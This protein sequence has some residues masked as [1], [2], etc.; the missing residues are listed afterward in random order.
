MKK[1]LFIAISALSLLAIASCEKEPKIDWDDVT[2]NGFYVSG[3]ATGIDGVSSDCVMAAGLNEVDKTKRAGMYE[4][5]IVLEAGKEFYLLYNDGK[6]KSRYS[7]TLE[8]FTTP[9]EEAYSDNPAQVL[10]GSLVIGNDAPAMKVSKT[11]LYHIVLDI[12]KAN[13]LGEKYKDGVIVLL[14]ASDFG[15]RGGMNSWGFTSSDP[16]PEFKNEGITF[17]FK[18][19]ELAKNGE[20]KFSTGNYWKVTLDDAGKVKA[21][22]SLGETG[23]GLGLA[24]NNNI[25]VEKGGT[26]DITLTFKLA[27]GEFNKSFTYTAECTKESTAPETMYMI[28]NAFGNWDWASDGIVELSGIPSAPGLF[29]CTRYFTAADEFKFCA[30]KAWNGDFGDN[31]NNCKV[32]SDGFYTVFVDGNN[33]KAEIM[34]AEVYGIGDAWGADA[35]DFNAPDA[36]K[37]VAEGQVLKATVKNNSTAVR[38][39]SKVTPSAPIEGVTTGNGWIDWWKTEFVY[40]DGKI[41]YRGAGNDQ[42]RVA[43]EAG[44]VITIDFNAGTVTVTDGVVQKPTVKDFAQGFVKILDVW[45]TTTG[46]GIMYEGVDPVKNAHLIPLDTKLTIAGKEYTTADLWET[47]IRSY[48]LIRGYNGLDTENY[49]A[50]KIGPLSAGAQAMSDLDIPE[51]HQYAWGAGPCNETSGNGGHLVRVV[52]GKDVHCQVQVDILDNFAMRALNF[53][54]GKTISNM[55]T[56]PRDPI[57]NYKGSFCAMRGLITYAFFFKHMLDNNLEKGTDVA[58]DVIIRSELFGDES[59]APAAVTIKT[60]DEFLAWAAE[61]VADA[62]LEADITL[63]A[64]FVP[65]TLKANF[66]G[67]GHKIT[68]EVTVPAGS[69]YN[70]GL[71]SV[72]DGSVKNL[73][74]AGKI[75][76]EMAYAGGIAGS[77]AENAVFENCESSV[78]ITAPIKTTY[79]L[80]GIVGNAA[81]GIT[82]KNCVNN[83]EINHS[84]ANL[85]A[86]N[87]SQIGGIIGHIEANGTITG[88]TNNGK[89]VYS[90]AGTPRV[91]G[92]CGYINVLEDASI[93]DCT[94]NGEIL[95]ESAATS[96]YNYVGGIT[97]YYGTPVN[98]SHVLYKNCKNTANITLD[99]G[100]AKTQARV[101]GIMCH[102][103]GT[104]VDAT[105]PLSVEVINCSNSGNITTTGTSASQHVG[106][107]IA[108]TE[109]TTCIIKCDGCSNTGSITVPGN[110]C[111]GSILGYSCNPASTFTNFTCGK[112]VVLT[113][114]ATGKAGLVI[115]SGYVSTEAI[116]NAEL[117]TALT[118]K[119]LGGK[120]VFGENAT[121]ATSANYKALLVFAGFVG[122]ADGVTFGN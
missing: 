100:V 43:V 4:K 54:H 27:Q 6:N 51:T 31:G 52:D 25:K 93:I 41:A 38:L 34:P 15:V 39:S 3:P 104:A 26:Y 57:N 73:K 17:T 92:M 89:L 98:S 102:C 28:G 21:E 113:V 94:N 79:R 36:V 88:C 29:W 35:W 112:D 14:D 111:I 81:K 86:G 97:G 76:T 96:G 63:P 120:V 70:A 44:K 78:A 77:V 32:A 18:D 105:L 106:G 103:G 7:A 101:G 95:V 23:N 13:D 68:Y 74:V 55:C 12:N 121:E 45:E 46:D 37:F 16:K 59:A 82:L 116:P 53:Q 20:F 107:V 5:Y 56:Y 72:V 117:N 2:V 83:G 118:G 42:E 108:F 64:S 61:G 122:S 10:K 47:A 9:E 109:K 48:L 49:G 50:G 19:Q 58:A 75:S 85:G 119:V 60:A 71:F 62:S 8:T 99:K 65:D 67:K 24:D 30:V 11:G 40:F 33:N 110:G 22:T 90:A 91:G 114:G 66:D 69:T 84:I 1:L 115:G 87:A 80:G